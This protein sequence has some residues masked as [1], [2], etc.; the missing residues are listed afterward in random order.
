MSLIY[1]I[2]SIFQ[3]DKANFQALTPEIKALMEFRK[4]LM[5][6]QEMDRYIAR[7]DYAFLR[8][9]YSDTYTFFEN[10]KRANTLKYYCEKNALEKSFVDKFLSEYEDV[11]LNEDSLIIAKHNEQYVQHHLKKEKDYLQ[12][13]QR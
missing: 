10:T 8:E 4:K 7:S 13:T 5:S 12:L 9:H 3:S 11:C 6:F 2:L 1:K